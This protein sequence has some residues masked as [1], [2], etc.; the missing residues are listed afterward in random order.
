MNYLWDVRL[1]NVP[2]ASRDELE[3]A[4][5]AHHAAFAEA[6]LT[7]S[8]PVLAELDGMADGS[9]EDIE[10]DLQRL[11]DRWKDMR[12]HMRTCLGAEEAA[13]TPRVQP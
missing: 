11:W 3:A 12:T 9:F 10:K 1:G 8:T 5:H 4:R 2:D 7:A 13:R 6:Q